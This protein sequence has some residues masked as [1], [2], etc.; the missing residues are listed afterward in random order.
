MRT[1]VARD[2]VWAS[3]PLEADTLP[4]ADTADVCVVGAGIAGLSVAYQLAEVG[5]R[6]LVLD[7]G[8]VGGGQTGRTTA[9]LAS[10]IDDRLY[11]IERIRGRQNAR[12]AAESHAA[13]IDCIE[14]VVVRERIDCSFE[15]VD[16]HLFLAPGDSEALLDRECEA[17][18]RAGLEV[19]RLRSVT[20][21][22]FDTGPCLR[23]ARQA[24]FDPMRYCAGLVRAIRARG[25]RVV[26]GV[27]VDRVQGGKSA[28]IV[29][30]ERTLRA[31]AVVLATNAP[32][33][34]RVVIH[35]K[36]APYVTYAIAVRMPHAAMPHALYWDTGDPYHYV[37]VTRARDGGASDLLVV[38]GEDHKT[39]QAH[40]QGERF[41]RLERWARERFPAVQDVV[42]AWSGQV[43]ETMD[44]L[45]F[46]GRNPA[47]D[48]NVFLATGDSG[49]GMTHGTIAGLLVRDLILRRD[50]PW[51]ALYEPSRRPPLAAGDYLRENANVAVQY[52]SWVTPGDVGSVAEIPRGGGAVVRDGLTKTAVYRD[53]NG[54]LHARSAVCPHLKAIVTWNPAEKTWDC[55]AHGSRFDCHGTVIEGPANGNLASA[56]VPAEPKPAASLP[57]DA[58]GVPGP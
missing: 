45:G 13:A 28:R 43:H 48:G 5:Q 39:G 47:D 57:S 55:P 7:D 17:A 3:V 6:V 58:P 30:R 37:R 8:P 53:E 46:I 14:E 23:F 21:A 11:E 10:A 42:Y 51:R 26:T 29:T 34:D 25:G 35:T 9:H 33:N 49:M 19:E 22:G 44:G 16:G 36:Q 24:Q 56:D 27:H 38:G 41:A 50:N 1:D 52:G 54:A 20:A 15:R 32:V 12:L 2:S 31:P 40:D 4:T 18:R